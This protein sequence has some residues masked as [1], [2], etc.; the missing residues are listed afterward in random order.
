M[1]WVWFLALITMGM[2]MGYTDEPLWPAECYDENSQFQQAIA[3]HFIDQLTDTF[4][5]PPGGTLLDV[6]CGNG[7]ITHSLLHIFSPSEI[8]GIDASREMI[9]FANQ[10]IATDQLTFRVDRAETLATIPP[11]SFDAIVSFSCLHW[12]HDQARAYQ[13]MYDSLKPGGWIGLMFPA[14]TDMDDPL[15]QAFAKAFSQEPYRTYFERDTSH[16]DWNFAPPSQIENEL[17]A[18]GF[19]IV[20]MQTE[21]VDYSYPSVEKL[22]EWILACAQQLRLLPPDLQ[23]ACAMQIAQ[24]Y[25]DASR[26]F[27]PTDGSCIYRLDPLM[28]TAIKSVPTNVVVD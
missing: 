28:I 9:E 16:V 6:G 22:K 10:Y 8:V 12:V 25:L 11:L 18:A 13:R 4:T 20:S 2:P 23:E 21:I 19:E 17:K 24:D 7:P 5:L 3:S 27:Q 14:D 15:D 1:K 26:D